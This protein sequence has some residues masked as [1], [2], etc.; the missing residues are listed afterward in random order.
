MECVCVIVETIYKWTDAFQR[1]EKKNSEGYFVNFLVEGFFFF[2]SSYV[3]FLSQ[4]HYKHL[5]TRTN[6]R[7]YFSN[8]L[9]PT[10]RC[11]L[12][13]CCLWWMKAVTNFI[14]L[15]ILPERSIISSLNVPAFCFILVCIRY[16]CFLSFFLIL[17]LSSVCVLFLC[18]WKQHV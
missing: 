5:H 6:T 14:G 9:L 15:P 10:R 1:D 17:L 7:L 2:A 8:F 11:V 16:V 4:T 13:F 18:N 3:Y 12:F